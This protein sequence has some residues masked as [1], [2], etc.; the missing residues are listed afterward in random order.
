MHVHTHRDTCIHTDTC[1]GTHTDVHTHT[2]TFLGRTSQGNADSDLL[3]ILEELLHNPLPENNGP[4]KDVRKQRLGECGGVQLWP[5]LPTVIQLIVLAAP[6]LCPHL[7][8]SCPD[9]EAATGTWDVTHPGSGMLH[10]RR[11]K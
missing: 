10:C 1:T 2:H 8:I 11:K 3:V 9:S 5:A 4:R 6:A 7:S